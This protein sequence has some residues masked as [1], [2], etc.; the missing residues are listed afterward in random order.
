MYMNSSPL[1]Y[2]I[3]FIANT[4]FFYDH[5]IS[6]SGRFKKPEDAKKALQQVNGL[7]IAGRQIKVGLV[8]ETKQEAGGFG[9]SGGDLDDDG[10]HC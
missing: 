10:K 6:I 7:E 8:N 1:M 4:I 9:T 3:L 5:C 2:V